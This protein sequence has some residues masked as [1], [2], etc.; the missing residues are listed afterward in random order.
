[1]MKLERAFTYHGSLAR[2][3][4]IVNKLNPIEQ[5]ALVHANFRKSWIR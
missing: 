2:V 3:M 4:E 1:L 5:I